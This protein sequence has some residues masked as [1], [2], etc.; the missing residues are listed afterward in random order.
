MGKLNTENDRCFTFHNNDVIEGVEG[1][2]PYLVIYKYL[3]TQEL[4]II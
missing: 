1:L 3:N 2:L 4:F